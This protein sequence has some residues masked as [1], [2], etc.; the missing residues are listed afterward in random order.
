MTPE[1]RKK[2]SAQAKIGIEALIDEATGYQKVRPKD[3]L[4]RRYE[5][6]GGEAS[7][8]RAPDA[9]PVGQEDA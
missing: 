3:D 8:Y 4:Q 7:D 5:T 9:P 1:E 2:L 6:Y